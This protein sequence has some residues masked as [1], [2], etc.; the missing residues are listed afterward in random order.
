M[1]DHLL[2]VLERERRNIQY[3]I[4][5][6]LSFR[7]DCASSLTREWEILGNTFI[8]MFWS[9][10]NMIAHLQPWEYITKEKRLAMYDK[11][12]YVAHL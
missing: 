9:L 3:S 7:D 4:V 6:L 2:S 11:L 5:H 12:S 1:K 10:D 8:A